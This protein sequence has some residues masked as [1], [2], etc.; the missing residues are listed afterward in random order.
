ML[1]AACPPLGVAFAIIDAVL[2]AVTIFQVA[3]EI[4]MWVRQVMEGLIDLTPEE[5]AELGIKAINDYACNY[6]PGCLGSIPG[7][8]AAND[9]F[10]SEVLGYDA[11]GGAPPDG[12]GSVTPSPA[13]RRRFA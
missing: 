4:T 8:G 7:I 9:W 6:L 1:S 11:G 13:A 10:N 2:I 12:D 3:Y 5:M